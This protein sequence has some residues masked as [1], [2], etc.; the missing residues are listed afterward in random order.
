MASDMQRVVTAGYDDI[1]DAYFERFGISTVRQ[2]WLRRLIDGLPATGSRVLDLGCGPGIPV[3]HDLAALGHT[4]VGVDGSSQQI[5]R[6]RLNVPQATFIEADMCSVTFE[7]GSFDAAGAFYSIIHVPP[8]QQGALIARIARW[9]K[10]GGTLVASFGTGAPGEWTGEWLGTTM[11][12]GHAGETEALRFLAE[13]GLRVRHSSV[14][15]QDNEEATF[16]WIEAAKD[17]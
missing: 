13:A 1:A 5:D 9:L 17:R 7:A 4:V 14:E 3:A 10:P 8:A 2:K 16:M 15:K 6:A 11:F 12:F